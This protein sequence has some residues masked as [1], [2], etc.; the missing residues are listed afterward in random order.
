MFKFLQKKKKKTEEPK[1]HKEY[2][3]DVFMFLLDEG[4][5]FENIKYHH[6]SDAAITG[7]IRVGRDVTFFLEVVGLQDAMA[8]KRNW[9]MGLDEFRK[10]YSHLKNQKRYHKKWWQRIFRRKRNL[11]QLQE[12]TQRG[13]MGALAKR[14]SNIK[15]R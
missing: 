6:F 5:D 12:A 3:G 11:Q 14:L 9:G 15:R 13:D 7:D 1:E 4:E 2:M 8:P 10:R